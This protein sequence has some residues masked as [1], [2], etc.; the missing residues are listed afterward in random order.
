MITSMIKM[1]GEDI[2]NE[3]QYPLICETMESSI[4]NTGHRR[5]TYSETFT[6]SEQKKI[7]EIKKQAHNWYLVKGAPDENTARVVAK[8]VISSSL[9]KAAMLWNRLAEFCLS[10]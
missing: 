8:S 2:R 10:L 7:S 5:R 3:L 6:R 1:T 4:W 9:V